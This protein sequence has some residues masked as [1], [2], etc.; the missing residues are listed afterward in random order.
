VERLLDRGKTSGRADDNEET[1][2]N[3]IKVFNSSTR[4]ALD[5]YWRFGK[6]HTISSIGSVEE[7]YSQVLQQ[8]QKNLIFLYGAPCI[9]K[10]MLAKALC[11][12]TGYRHV[13]LREFWSKGGWSQEEKVNRLMAFFEGSKEENFIIDGFFE[14]LKQAKIF[15]ENFLKPKQVFYFETTKDYVDEKLLLVN[16]KEKEKAYKE[17]VGNRKELVDFFKRDPSFVT[18]TVNMQAPIAGFYTKIVNQYLAPEVYFA[19]YEDNTSLFTSYVEALEKERGF[20]HLPLPQ[21]LKREAER[22]TELGLEIAKYDISEVPLDFQIA[23]LRKILF[24]QQKRFRYLITGFPNDFDSYRYFE[25]TCREISFVITFEAEGQHIP[26]YCSSNPL[27][28]PQTYY[29]TIG[30][31]M[32][33][34]RNSLALFD[35]YTQKKNAYYLTIAPPYFERTVISK[36][37]SEKFG[38]GFIEWEETL[39]K[40]KEKLGGDDGPV[41]ELNFGQILKHFQDVFKVLQAKGTALVFDGFPYTLPDLE[42][43]IKTIGAPKGILSMEMSKESIIRAYRVNK[44]I[45][46]D[47]EIPEEEM[48]EINKGKEKH[49]TFALALEKIAEEGFGTNYYKINAN[50]SM[51]TIKNSVE[52][53]FF[54]RVY[55]VSH[56]FPIYDEGLL[57]DKFMQIFANIAARNQCIFIDVRALI[58]KEFKEEGPLFEKLNSQYLMRWTEKPIDFPSNYTPELIM[59]LV[60]KHLAGITVQ[61]REIMIYNYSMGDYQHDR[62]KEECCFPRALDELAQIEGGLGQIK[63]IFSINE[64]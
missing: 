49:E 16:S 12:V 4:P 42:L 8:L 17:F 47:A 59:E 10:T 31:H 39:T 60:K 35:H 37:L 64:G 9:G 52:N 26:F 6:V 28:T 7:V 19:I 34:D 51:S 1:I 2:R 55:L 18:F 11:Q 38:L 43:F 20:I 30:K 24:R 58:R 13:E 46:L 14:S 29:H 40:L 48:E 61:S 45:E 62:K 25:E 22:K 23:L 63:M 21:L 54:K 5:Y 32:I 50:I 33:I 53:L 15:V 41:D 27:F 44:G 3:R 36:H 56:S 57:D